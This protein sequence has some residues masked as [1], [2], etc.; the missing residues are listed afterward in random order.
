MNSNKNNK[1]KW[2]DDALEKAIGSERKEA[3]F[4]SFKQK[5]TQAIERL[6]GRADRSTAAR[7]LNIWRIIMKSRIT[8][9]AA[10]AVIII[11]VMTGIYEYFGS[12]DGA[13]VAFADIV[14]K[15]NEARCVV[16]Y[17]QINDWEKTKDMISDSGVWRVE[18]PNGDITLSDFPGGK[19]LD[20]MSE[21]KRALLTHKIG[22]KRPQRLFNCLTWLQQFQGKGEFASIE[23][24]DGKK[25]ELF[26]CEEPYL[27][28]SVWVDVESKL[29]VKAV[30]FFKA[31]PNKDIV[32]PVLT[33]NLKDFGG[34]GDDLLSMSKG[35]TIGI[36]EEMTIVM[37][38]F[39]WGA[40][41]DE[42]LF[43]LE[44]PE[45]Y[46]LEERQHDISERG[47][48]WLIDA[49]ALWT[50]MSG[51]FFPDNINDLCDPN[52]ARP[53]LTSKFDKDGDPKKEFDQAC[54]QMPVLVEGLYFA[55]ERKVDGSW[56][57]VGDGVKLGESDVPICW[58]KNKDSDTYRII[59]GDLS[60]ADSN[61][62]PQL[63]N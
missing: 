50:D 52:I 25:T 47:E 10:A 40:E 4:E 2:L 27:K 3:D 28:T 20:L 44:T 11:A 23:Q 21:S 63:E 58:W 51:G 12:I 42:S 56:G 9:L 53:L 1:E 60:I 61:D 7:S 26:I 31:H 24:V 16:F 57:Y 59:Y 35:G 22:R 62:V 5:H 18:F 46:S 37:T 39:E 13:S 34:E 36:S 6:T 41:L 33:V 17:Q 29:P 43:S 45:G 55:Q 14:E 32:A 8:K 30:R 49:L 38:D 54:K 48:R 15:I 19:Q